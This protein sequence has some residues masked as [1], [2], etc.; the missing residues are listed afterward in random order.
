MFCLWLIFHFQMLAHIML[1][2]LFVCQIY[3][4][5][6]EPVLR[7]QKSMPE[8]IFLPTLQIFSEILTNSS[9]IFFY[10][11]RLI[12]SIIGKLKKDLKF[13]QLFPTPVT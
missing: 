10:E 4:M 7:I 1:A 5:C 13:L 12:Y 6:Y 2:R 11:K 3:K 9:L 8:T